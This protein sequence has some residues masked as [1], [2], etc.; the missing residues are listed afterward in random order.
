MS[1]ELK[2]LMSGAV[3]LKVMITSD[4]IFQHFQE[5]WIKAIDL[6]DQSSYMIYEI[7]IHNDDLFDTQVPTTK[8]T[9]NKSIDRR[10]L[11]FL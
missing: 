5:S 10:L 7:M 6:T 2:I 8:I 4:F 11:F 9:C 1:F 3:S